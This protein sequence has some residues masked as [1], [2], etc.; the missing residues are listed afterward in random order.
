MSL[1]LNTSEAFLAEL[2]S[3]SLAIDNLDSETSDCRPADDT[4]PALGS[5]TAVCPGSEPSLPARMETPPSAAVSQSSTTS[6]TAAATPR[7][8]PRRLL[9][10]AQQKS[11]ICQ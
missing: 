9:L 8:R 3:I 5:T 4:F 7:R 11:E 1:D 6:V 10:N 2:I